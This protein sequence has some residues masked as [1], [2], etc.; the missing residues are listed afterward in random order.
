MHDVLLIYGHPEADPPPE[1]PADAFPTWADATAALHEA[2]AFVAGAG[3]EGTGTATTARFRG[4]RLLTDGPFAETKEHLLGLYVVD[5]PDLDAALRWAGRMP[6]VHWGSV[7][8][9]PVL[10][11]APAAE[12]GAQA[13]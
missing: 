8:V 7:E 10:P 4:E 5:V 2:G 13:A 9:R 11:A 12:T 3:L 1:R 6:N